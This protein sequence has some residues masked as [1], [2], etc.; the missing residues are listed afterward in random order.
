MST[1]TSSTTS[2][3]ASSLSSSIA[4]PIAQRPRRNKFPKPDIFRPLRRGLNQIQI[5]N[6]RLAH[7]ICR[8]IPGSCPFERDLTLFGYTIHVPALCKLNPVYEEIVALRFRAL[9]YLADV[10]EE[11]ISFYLQ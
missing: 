4:S 8:L 1:L 11:D 5:R 7:R 6:Y 10:Y 9:C 2:F 3:P